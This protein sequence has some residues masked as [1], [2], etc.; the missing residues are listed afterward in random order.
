QP[1]DRKATEAALHVSPAVKVHLTWQADTLTVTP[2]H[3]FAPNAA[4][5]L[6][7]AR[8]AARTAA[9]AR[10]AAAIHVVVGTAP[11]PGTGHPARPAFRLGRAQVA[12]A[13]DGS[14]AVIARTGALLLTDARPGRATDR[15]SGLVRL[16]NGT[17]F[18]I[19]DATS[20]ICLSRTGSSIA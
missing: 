5:L 13:N 6:T 12:G 10:L 1:L 15:H 9:G 17:A 8:D 20:A 14:E 19:S 7:I 18:K 4:Y 16:E 11:V 2:E 3:G